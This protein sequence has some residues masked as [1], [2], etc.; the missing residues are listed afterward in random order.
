M[1]LERLYDR[2]YDNKHQPRPFL[3]NITPRLSLDS[4]RIN[5]IRN[6]AHN[7]LSPLLDPSRHIHLDHGLDDHTLGFVT[8][9]NS[10]R[11]KQTSFFR[12]K[13]V[14]FEVALG[15]D[16]VG[17]VER[18]KGEDGRGGTRAIIVGCR[19]PQMDLT[20][21]AKW[22]LGTDHSVQNV[23]PGAGKK[24]NKLVLS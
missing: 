18:F 16:K 21:S 1:N 5:V 7:L 20:R 6:D 22:K 12:G 8:L 10:L 9:G 14:E 11:S 13:P 15:G 19:H 23:P 17:F 2:K 4:P 24:G 3:P